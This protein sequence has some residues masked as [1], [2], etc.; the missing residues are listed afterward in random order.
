MLNYYIYYRV[1][2]DDLDTERQIRSMQAKL[3]CRTG[4]YGSLLKRQDDAFTWMEIYANITD[5]TAFGRALH[6][7]L[8]EFDIEMF[9]NGKRITECFIGESEQ[10]HHCRA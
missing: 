5:Q 1:L 10:P 6:Q 2:T 7:A 9:I 4:V 8:S 3:G